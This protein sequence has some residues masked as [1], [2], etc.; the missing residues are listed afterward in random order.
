[1]RRPF[2]F[3]S[4]I[5][6]YVHRVI[7]VNPCHVAESSQPRTRKAISSDPAKVP[8]IWLPFTDKSLA[9][10]CTDSFVTM[11]KYDQVIMFLRGCAYHEAAHLVSGEPWIVVKQ[12]TGAVWWSND[13]NDPYPMEDVIQPIFCNLINDVN[14]FT[15]VPDKWAISVPYSTY[16]ADT[17]F[18][19]SPPN[20][21]MEFSKYVTDQ[22]NTVHREWEDRKADP[23]I[24]D[25]GEEP[26]AMGPGVTEI[27]RFQN[28][29]LQYLRSLKVKYSGSGAVRSL[30]ATDVAE[31]IFNGKV[32]PLVKKIR[33]PKCSMNDR[34]DAIVTLRN[35]F[36]E[37]YA[38]VRTEGEPTFE[39]LF[40]PMA[41]II[42]ARPEATSK[43]GDDV[44]PS[45]P[46]YPEGEEPDPTARNKGHNKDTGPDGI[47]P[48]VLPHVDMI[49]SRKIAHTLNERLAMRR[50]ERRV[51]G[52]KTGRRISRRRLPDLWTRPD[53]PRLRKPP[54]LPRSE[55]ADGHIVAVW[56][57]SGSMSG[58]PGRV[59]IDTACTLF[60]ALFFMPKVLVSYA[61][62]GSPAEYVFESKP[63]DLEK[64]IGK[65]ATDLSPRGE[66]DM[67]HGLHMALDILEKSRAYR[68]LI[69]I[70]ND[71]DLGSTRHN[72]IDEM[73]RAHKLKIPVV[74][75]D[76]NASYSCIE[77]MRDILTSKGRGADIEKF[78]KNVFRINDAHDLLH[79]VSSAT[80]EYM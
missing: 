18:W 28:M 75:L 31:S 3:G 22:F 38:K 5:S 8:C 46:S 65:I 54:A 11:A 30:P 25:P 15:F 63:A 62:F 48:E 17:L 21:P 58:A 77:E 60:A 78:R 55:H 19:N 42:T 33:N 67:P 71:G 23:D 44:P 56:D 39:E 53:D 40:D 79:A 80:L 57:R 10:F 52:A 66:N 76:M 69:L 49:M 45:A 26:K 6:I 51:S 7:G 43:D 68:K 12:T 59:S 27:R 64:T 47:K 36:R 37:F 41:P 20:E 72:V 74:I 9:G 73:D 4:D 50:I 14:D 1:M 2:D 32:I 35:I 16:L 29:Y 34:A 13:P 61:H 24:D 70:S